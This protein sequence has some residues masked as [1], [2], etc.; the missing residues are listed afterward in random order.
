MSGCSEHMWIIGSV[1]QCVS[2]CASVTV[3]VYASVCG[4]VSESAVCQCGS[5]NVC[6]VSASVSVC[7]SV[8][9]WLIVSVCQSVCVCQCQCQ[10]VSVPESVSGQYASVFHSV[11]QHHVI[12][13][14]REGQC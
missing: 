5:V 6:V 7:Q 2:E 10:C 4:S 3:S 1:C 12:E 9:Q 13:C 14:V 8:Y 11:V